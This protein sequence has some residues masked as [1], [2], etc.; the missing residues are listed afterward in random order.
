VLVADDNV[1]AA[2]SF[3][4]ILGM[5][6]YETLVVTDGMQALKA[7]EEF[8]PDA[9]LLDL[10]MPGLSGYELAR[11]LRARPWGRNMLLVAVTGWGQSEDRRRSREAG[12]DHHFV[13]PVDP[14]QIE[15]LLEEVSSPASR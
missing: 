5:M 2:E 11:E 9:A 7:A 15:R 3:G 12:F 8:E 4:E 13:K 14:S 10:G 1:D 6:G